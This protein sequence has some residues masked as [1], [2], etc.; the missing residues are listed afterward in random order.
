MVEPAGYIG[1]LLSWSV[2]RGDTVQQMIDSLLDHQS[3]TD[4]RGVAPLPAAANPR[5]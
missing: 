4:P 1:N 3:V 5:A 2:Q